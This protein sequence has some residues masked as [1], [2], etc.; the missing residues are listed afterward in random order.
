MWKVALET[1]PV[2]AILEG[3][4]ELREGVLRLFGVPESELAATLRDAEASEVPVGQLEI[5][6]C[7]HG[8][9]LEV[10]TTY[11]PHSQEGYDALAE[12]LV[13]RHGDALFSRDGSTVD[14]QVAALL[15]AA[16][17]TIATAES[18]TG[19]LLSARLTDVPGSSRYVLGGVVAYSNDVKVSA[20]A[21]PAELIAHHG[22]VSQEVA[23]ALADGARSRLGADV[24]VGITGVA[25][26]GGGSA[27]KP[28]GLV[29]I[30]VAG[31]GADARL[32]RS[33]QLPGGRSDV[34]ELATTLA[35]HLL[36]RVLVRDA[37][38]GPPSG[39]ARVGVP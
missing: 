33:V 24:G 21:V 31:P 30:S 23:E 4:S 29:W 5:T 16:G 17:L 28:V 35:M 39:A 36:R 32:T 25:G 38:K 12:F 8:G 34:R 20:A 10:T 6:T 37:S 27:E 26:P 15:L 7:L 9:E 22:A 18:C 19:G 3:A 13:R 2:R 11:T 1:E 14:E